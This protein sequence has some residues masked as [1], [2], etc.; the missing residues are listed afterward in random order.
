MALDHEF[1][2]DRFHWCAL[3][4]GLMAAADGTLADSTHVRRLAYDLYE[5]GAF[6]DPVDSSAGVR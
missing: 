2:A 3:A 1:W 5:Q 6:A 4:A